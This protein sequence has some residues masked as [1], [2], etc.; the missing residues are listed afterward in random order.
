MNAVAYIKN[1]DGDPFA[2]LIQDDGGVDAIGQSPLGKEWAAWVDALG[3]RERRVIDS[4]LWS[5][6]ED[7]IID[8]PRT[9]KRAE[10]ADLEALRTQEAL[11]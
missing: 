6:S 9:P 5:L 7:Q 8:G 10:R 1:A 3:S 11:A 2:V 4:V